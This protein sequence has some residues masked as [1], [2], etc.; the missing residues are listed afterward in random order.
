MQ[1][2]EYGGCSGGHFGRRDFMRVG[3]LSFLGINLSQFLH[4]RQVMASEALHEQAKAQACILVWL[5]GGPSQMDTWDPKPSSNF[6]PISTNVPGIQISELFPRMA[7]LMD[8][9]AII[10]SM[11]TEENNHDV[12]THNVATGHR[13]NPAMKFPGIGAIITHQLGPRNE[14]PP[15]VIVPSM[16]KG[17]L[18]D[19]Y[20][21]A[22]FLGPENDP[23]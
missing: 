12:G 21:K 17:R 7:K 13:P 22:H 18:Y 15:H 2:R 1:T 3:T 19:E 5:D 4:L 10:R 14:V 16:P 8:K 9:C 23:M 6:K 11:H 20:F